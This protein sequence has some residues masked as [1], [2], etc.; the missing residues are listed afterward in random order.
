MNCDLFL[1]KLSGI[2]FSD[3]I[4]NILSGHGWRNFFMVCSKLVAMG[5][6]EVKTGLRE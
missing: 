6:Y 2:D 3:K 1:T 5:I 4:I